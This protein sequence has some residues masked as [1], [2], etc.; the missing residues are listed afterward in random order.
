[1][2]YQRI[3]IE[4]RD[5]WK[6]FSYPQKEDPSKFFRGYVSNIKRARV[7][8]FVPQHVLNFKLKRYDNVSAK[9]GSFRLKGSNAL[10]NNI[11]PS[12]L[13]CPGEGDIKYKD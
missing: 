2:E 11:E 13:I 1:M 10:K 12:E 8:R 4:E 3:W 7:R 9:V 5:S 6:K